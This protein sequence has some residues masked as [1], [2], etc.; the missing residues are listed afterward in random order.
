VGGTWCIAFFGASSCF[1][2]RLKEYQLHALSSKRTAAIFW[3]LI[4]P[5]MKALLQCRHCSCVV[6]AQTA[7]VEGRWV[8]AGKAYRTVNVLGVFIML[9]LP[10]IAFPVLVRNV[11]SRLIQRS[12]LDLAT[13]ARKSQAT[14]GKRR[15]AVERDRV[16]RSPSRTRRSPGRRRSRK[17]SVNVN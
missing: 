9:F 3:L 7:M 16:S 11:K 13:R 4:H 17:R 15:T 14:A 10:G 2:S 12:S 8:T 1:T 6:K 5:S